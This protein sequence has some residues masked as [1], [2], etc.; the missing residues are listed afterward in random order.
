MI[1]V[2]IIEDEPAVRKEISYLIQQEADTVLVGWSDH[3]Q[4]AV[5]LIDEKQPDVVLMD[6]QLQDGTA[7]DLLKRLNLELQLKVGDF[8][9]LPIYLFLAASLQSVWV[10]Y[11]PEQN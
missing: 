3:V 10:S 11:S 6:I 4:S 7:F 5:K 1:T 9:M 8:F 2:V